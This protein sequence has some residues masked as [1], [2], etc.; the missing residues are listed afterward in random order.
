M[1]ATK[2]H[3]LVMRAMMLAIDD[4]DE[5]AVMTELRGIAQGDEQA[6][7]QAINLLRPEECLAMRAIKPGGV[8]VF[9]WAGG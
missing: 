3:Q 7:E 9:A 5:D 1:T 2:V 4:L 8:L 6:L